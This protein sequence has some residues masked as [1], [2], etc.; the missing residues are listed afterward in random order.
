MCSKMYRLFIFP[1]VCQSLALAHR[2]N[3]D[4]SDG[5]L[6]NDCV[7]SNVDNLGNPQLPAGGLSGPAGEVAGTADFRFLVSRGVNP[8]ILLEIGCRR[9]AREYAAAQDSAGNRLEERCMASR[10][11]EMQGPKQEMMRGL[12]VLR[13]KT[14]KLE[15]EV[16]EEDVTLPC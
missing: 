13:S 8:E 3:D 6:S 7:G 4:L 12:K 14:K 5:I 2:G 1:C 16:E 10:K 9:D 15:Q 11:S